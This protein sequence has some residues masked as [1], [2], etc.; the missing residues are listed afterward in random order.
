MAKKQVR[1]SSYYEERLIRDHS[2]YYA[3]YHDGKYQTIT[4]AAIA[5]GL[6]K[7]RT[8]LHELKNAWAK[9]S[10]SERKAFVAWLTASRAV[11]SGT[12]TPNTSAPSPTGPPVNSDGFIEPWAKQR[13]D[14]IKTKRGISVRTIRDEMGLKSSD[15]SLESALQTHGSRLR[16]QTT[17]DA[18]VK[19]LASQSGV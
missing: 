3:D 19:W 2:T 14:D 5:A 18:L 15:T 7:P 16:R 8:R 11:A 10:L 6:K 13:I 12:T 17:I 4:E 9:A 1:D